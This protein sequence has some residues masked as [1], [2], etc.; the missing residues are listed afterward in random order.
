[1][2]DVQV[3]NKTTVMFRIAS[4]RIRE[5]VLRRKYW[6]IADI[7]LVVSAWNPEV[8]QAPPDLSAMPMWIDLRGV[9]GYLFSNK[10]LELCLV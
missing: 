5:R 4:L 1:M 9:P 8:S 3:I 2:I 10:G 7:P 6:H